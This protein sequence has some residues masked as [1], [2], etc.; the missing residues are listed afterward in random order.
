MLPLKAVFNILIRN[1]AKTGYPFP[2]DK[3]RCHKWARE[4]NLPRSK[5]TIMYTSCLY[6]LVPYI[7][8]MVNLLEKAEHSSF[9]RFGIRMYSGFSFM[10]KFSKLFIRVSD[11]DMEPIY[12]ILKSIAQLLMRSGVDFGYLYEDDIY[13]GALLYDL[14]LDDLFTKH[15][16]RVVSILRKNEVRRIITID[17]HTHHMFNTVY[18]EYV[19][20]FDFEVINYLNIL[21]EKL[22]ANSEETDEKYTIHDPCIYARWEGIISQ[23]RELLKKVGVRVQEPRRAGLNTGCCGGPIESMTPSM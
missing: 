2:L 6:Q 9:W 14:G 18:P 11:K 13:S 7:N 8:S 17:P 15:A 5:P 12:R 10:D 20:D 23:P 1:L 3:K 19:D 22:K 4:L 16:K 21:N